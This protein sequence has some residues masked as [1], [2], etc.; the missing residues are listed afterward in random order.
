MNTSPK[1]SCFLKLIL[2]KFSLFFFFST[3][4]SQEFPSK[5]IKI[6][7]G[8]VPGGSPDFI[9]RTLAQRMSDLSKVPVLVENKPGAG[10]STA[11]SFVGKSLP[12]GYTLFLGD[13]SHLSETL[14]KDLLPVSSITSEPLMLVSSSKSNIKSLQDLIMEAKTHPG[15]INYGSSG[16]GSIQHIAM[17]A[18]THDTGLKI[19]HVPYKGSGQ[20]VP[21]ILAGD[22]P[23]L[24]TSYTATAS[25]IKSG[26]LVLIGV[27]SAKRFSKFPS[28]PSLSEVI[29]DYD[30]TSETGVM[31]SAGAPKAVHQALI[32][33]IKRVCEDAQFASKFADTALSINFV[34]FPE[35]AEELKKGIKKYQTAMLRANLSSQSQ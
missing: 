32:S 7:V 3:C 15:E 4:L 12:D 9:A 10:G 31:T 29:K 14:L 35:F 19:T 2:F 16:V 18:F 28:V 5:P 26:A 34:P 8:Y 27:S 20:S 6:I 1:H 33:L 21:A 11:A 13:T 25:H 24:M 30:Y 17:D 22:V 23:L